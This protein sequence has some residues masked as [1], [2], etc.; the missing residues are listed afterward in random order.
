[1]LSVASSIFLDTIS[2]PIN[3][4]SATLNLDFGQ[5]EVALS[6]GENLRQIVPEESKV[7]IMKSPR[8]LSQYLFRNGTWFENRQEIKES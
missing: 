1:M 6:L 5:R 4:A 7:G 8:A 3:T 2:Q